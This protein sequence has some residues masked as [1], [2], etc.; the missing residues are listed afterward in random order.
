MCS[1]SVVFGFEVPKRASGAM[2]GTSNPPHSCRAALPGRSVAEAEANMMM[3]VTRMLFALALALAFLESN[4]ALAEDASPE[5]NNGRYTFSKV[6]QGVLRLD[7]QTG[8]VALCSQQTV[9]WA[10]QIAPEDR[11]LFES[12]IARLRSENASL[13]QELISHGLPLPPG[14][15]PERAGGESGETGLHLPSDADLNRVISFAGRIW[16]RLVEA[17]ANAQR[18]VLHGG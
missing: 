10:C 4:A 7:R 2:T 13:K 3:A 8:E 15:T 11:S 5:G 6:D 16:D 12:E 17:I 14:L 18:Q 1:L 9:G